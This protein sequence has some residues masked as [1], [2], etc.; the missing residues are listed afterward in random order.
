MKGKVK[1]DE[2]NAVVLEGYLEFLI[3]GVI[4]M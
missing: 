2:L 3:T 1:A 4:N